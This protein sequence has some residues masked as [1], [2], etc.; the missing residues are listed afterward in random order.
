MLLFDNISN[1][2]LCQVVPGEI[3]NSKYKTGKTSFKLFSGWATLR[4]KLAQIIHLENH[5]R[6]H[7]AVKGIIG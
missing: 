2:L 7:C 1:G 6:N 5:D 3:S 4:T